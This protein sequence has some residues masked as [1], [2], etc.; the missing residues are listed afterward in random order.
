MKKDKLPKKK[1]EDIIHFLMEAIW[2][3]DKVY[4][5]PLLKNKKDKFDRVKIK[6]KLNELLDHGLS[7]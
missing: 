4:G 5:L 6:K 2:E 1:D 7:D 3:Y